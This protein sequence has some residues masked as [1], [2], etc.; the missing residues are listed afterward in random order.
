[1]SW[2]KNRNNIG[3]LDLEV[4]VGLSGV[5]LDHLI[6]VFGC[7]NGLLHIGLSLLPSLIHNDVTCLIVSVV[8]FAKLI[9]NEIGLSTFDSGSHIQP[10]FYLTKLK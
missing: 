6:V 3:M 4:P 1:M 10:S 9:L 8:E 5:L 2:H 7:C